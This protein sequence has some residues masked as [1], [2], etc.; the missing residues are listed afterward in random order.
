MYISISVILY[1]YY[2]I[3]LFPTTQLNIY[4]DLG[5]L[6]IFFSKTYIQLKML[7]VLNISNIIIH[8]SEYIDNK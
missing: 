5:F 6:S 3:I 7:T 2:Y 8:F 1:L 4:F